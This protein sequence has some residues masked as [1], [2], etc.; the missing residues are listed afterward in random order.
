MTYTL[1]VFFLLGHGPGE[2]RFE[3]SVTPISDY[4]TC[5]HLEHAI[6]LKDFPAPC[7]L[8]GSQG[9]DRDMTPAVSEEM[10]AQL[11][12]MHSE[13]VAEGVNGWPVTVG[14]VIGRWQMPACQ[15]SAFFVASF[16]KP[17]QQQDH[18]RWRSR[19]SLMRHGRRVAPGRSAI[20]NPKNVPSFS[21]SSR[22]P[23]S[24]PLHHQQRRISATAGTPTRT[25]TVRASPHHQQ[26]R[27]PAGLIRSKAR[28]PKP[29]A[30]AR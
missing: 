25:T 13:M 15:K 12:K 18:Q 8:Q 3:K 24:P 11:K 6:N 28:R 14:A 20:N 7:H 23:S 1:V 9:E 22:Q 2:G 5:M 16:S 26:R 29:S 30:T 27:R 4:T 17:P 19:R 10:L 21:T